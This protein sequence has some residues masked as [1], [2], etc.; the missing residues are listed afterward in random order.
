MRTWTL[1][2]SIVVHFGF[3]AGV[4]VAP[5]FATDD[6]PVPP[7]VTEFV[8]VVAALPDPPSPR[9][10]P[11]PEQPSP[12]IAPLEAPERITPEEPR[13]PPRMVDTAELAVV[14][15][16][17]SP[18]A[19]VRGDI[20][21]GDL[22]APP[23]PPPVTPPAP[24]RV[25]GLVKEP[26]K[27]RDVAPRYPLVAQQTKV[28]GVVILEAVISESGVVQGVRVLLSKPLLDEAAV[29]AVRQWRF[30]P[31]LLNGQPVPV[32]MTVTVNFRLD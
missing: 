17:D 14:G 27:I 23:A 11:Q 20:A 2:L 1:G 13:E 18:G 9:R 25:G 3:I 15:G 29:E 30:T 32:V 26:Q 19:V 24:I 28:Q 16:V 31:T 7:R 10:P 22:V 21:G 12:H 6:L 8:R 4:V 5:L